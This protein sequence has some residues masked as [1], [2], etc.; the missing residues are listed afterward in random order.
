LYT[1]VLNSGPTGIVCRLNI[2]VDDEDCFV[3]MYTCDLDTKQSVLERT[4]VTL[5]APSRREDLGADNLSSTR[6]QHSSHDGL[7]TFPYR[8]RLGDKLHLGVGLRQV[9]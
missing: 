4:V 7:T 5:P 9:Q 8:T 1:I 6:R 2:L 3:C